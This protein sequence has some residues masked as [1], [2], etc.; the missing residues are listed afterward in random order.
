MAGTMT[1]I[2]DA[3]SP[4]ADRGTVLVVEDETDLAEM[5][6]FNLVREGYAC[7]VA[8]RGD[9]ALRK[10][11]QAHPDLV[12]LD[13]MLPG[14]SGDEVLAEIQRD[15]ATAEIPV[16]MLTAKTEESDQLVGFA[17][18]AAD[19]VSKPFSM[20]LL[21]ARISA[22]LRRRSG[23][24][25]VSPDDALGCGPIRIFPGRHEVFVDGAAVALTATEFRILA[26]LARAGGRVLS[27]S[28]LLDAACGEGVVVTDRTVDV[29]IT[30]LRRK[31]GESG[32]AWVQ[33]VR[34]VGYTLRQ[35][36]GA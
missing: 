29:H 18:G 21:L 9:E 19:Y 4:P 23:D 12:V 16:V 10:V 34:G 7:L 15:P 24:A 27:R 31:L 28:Q 25:G 20:K 3:S 35:P 2:A 6:R 32:A 26:A 36:G 30:A 11:A 33:T 13:R 14:L 22:I 8:G 17:L 5:L 1:A